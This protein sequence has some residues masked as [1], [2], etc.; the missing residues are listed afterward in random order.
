MSRRPVTVGPDMPLGA[1]LKRMLATGHQCFP[2]V[3]GA[4]V[5]GIVTGRDVVRALWRGRQVDEEETDERA[6]V[7]R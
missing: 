6:R 5:I 7:P 1:V 2:V 3:I 4:L